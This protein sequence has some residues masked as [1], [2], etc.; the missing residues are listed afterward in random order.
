MATF[1]LGQVVGPQGPQG[2]TGPQ[3]PQGI[4]GPAGATG[5]QG[6]RGL[7][8]EPGPAGAT[9]AAGPKGD[10]ATINGVNA[11]T[12]TTDETIQATQDAETMTLGIASGLASQS[13]IATNSYEQSDGIIVETPITPVTGSVVKFRNPTDSSLLRYSLYINNEKYLFLDSSGDNIVPTCTFESN[14]WVSVLVDKDTVYTDQYGRSGYRA[15]VL[16]GHY[17]PPYTYGTED[18]TA[19]TSE[20]ATGAIYLVYE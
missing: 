15:Y 18:L 3:G 16:N 2:E 5:A 17:A 1:D 4:Q 19:G 9:G 11:L 8:G 10:P 6:P 13:I 20:L 14:T 7:Q 12:L